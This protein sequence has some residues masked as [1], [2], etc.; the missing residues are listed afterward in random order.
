MQNMP[1]FIEIFT[2]IPLFIGHNLY[3]FK[4]KWLTLQLQKE[5]RC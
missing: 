4:N 5:R 2:S 3:I 1:H